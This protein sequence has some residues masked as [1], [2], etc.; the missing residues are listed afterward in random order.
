LYTGAEGVK[1]KDKE[2][3]LFDQNLI[4]QTVYAQQSAVLLISK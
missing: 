3:A 1:E 2:V 4:V